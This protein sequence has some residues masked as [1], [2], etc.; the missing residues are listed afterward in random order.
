MT[1]LDDIF[2]HLDTDVA[3]LPTKEEL[4]H[5]HD[6]KAPF[7]DAATAI[8][9]ALSGKATLTL[10]SKKTETRFTYKVTAS[11]DGAVHF[12]S[13]LGGPDNTSDYRYFGYIRRG[14]FFY[15]NAKAKVAVDAPSTKAFTWAWGAMMKGTMPDQLEVWHEGRCG[16]CG[17]K[18]TVPESLASGFGPECVQHIH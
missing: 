9:F 10:K 7:A 12:V 11:K 3:S 5:Q 18:L 6:M 16:R 14:I 4:K 17:R 13:L 2:A 1:M 15:G 8:K